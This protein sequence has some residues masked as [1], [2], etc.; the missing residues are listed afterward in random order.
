LSI[1][2]I[3]EIWGLKRIG[4]ALQ[5]FSALAIPRRETAGAI[6]VLAAL[7]QWLVQPL[8]SGPFMADC[9]AGIETRS[10]WQ[11][12]REISPWHVL[13]FLDSR[14]NWMRRVSQF[15]LLRKRE[16]RASI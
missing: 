5:K 13:S 12:V 7:T 10:V 14:K 9:E 11:Q 8:R 3:G 2:A 15:V 4:L 1:C 16:N 6:F